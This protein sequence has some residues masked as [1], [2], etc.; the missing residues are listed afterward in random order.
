PDLPRRQDPRGPCRGPRPAVARG[1]RGRR[2]GT[3]EQGPAHRAAARAPGR[4]PADA[5]HPGA[6]A[7]PVAGGRSGRGPGAVGALPGVAGAVGLEAR[8][9][10]RVTRALTVVAVLVLSAALAPA[11]LPLLPART[12]QSS[13]WAGAGDVQF[14]TLGWPRLVADVA[15]T[16]RSL[17][18][19]DRAHA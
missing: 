13:G 6:S 19:A 8:L 15:A 14:D 12:L 2:S 1:G 9:R 5:G 17:P 18:P 4:G 10:S 11:A 16:Y 7:E 3:A